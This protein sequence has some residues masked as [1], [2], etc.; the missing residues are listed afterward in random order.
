M[1]HPMDLLPSWRESA[2]LCQRREDIILFVGSTTPVR[3]NSMSAFG[4]P[5]LW[6]PLDQSILGPPPAHAM[7][8]CPPTFSSRLCF[9][10]CT[11]GDSRDKVL[12][13]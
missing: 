9:W 12:E 8:V 4:H 11:F 5:I 1:C 6:R 3:S 7:M 13:Y 2:E 10:E